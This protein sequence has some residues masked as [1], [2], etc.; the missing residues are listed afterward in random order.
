MNNIRKLLVLLAWVVVLGCL[1]GLGAAAGYLDNEALGTRLAQLAEKSPGL[2]TVR[3]L[4]KSQE[5]HEV[6]LVELGQ[7][8][9][10]DRNNAPAMLVV[11]GIEGND[12][13]GTTAVIEWIERL[14]GQPKA[15]LLLKE[16]EVEEGGLP[17]DTVDEKRKDQPQQ[18]PAEPM[19]LRK[20]P[21]EKP[22]PIDGLPSNAT[23]YVIPR[24]N[25]DAAARFFAK[26]PIESAT[27]NKPFDD[28]HDG[29]V[30]ED[31]PEDLN[32]DGQ[33]TM[34]RIRDPEGTY[35]L[36]PNEPRLLIEADKMKGEAGAWKL[37]AEGRDNDAD[38]KWNED[39]RGGV[40]FNR[41]FPFNYEWFA[42]DAGVHQVSEPETRALAD[43][44]VAHPNISV[45]FTFG[46]GDNLLAPP[47]GGKREGRKPLTKIDEDD[48]PYYKE[49][50]EIYRKALG[51]EKGL[52]N[53]TEPG[54]F[55]D[56]IYFHRGRLSLAARPWSPELHVALAEANKDAEKS[57]ESDKSDKP[58]RSDE[59]EKD[60]GDEKKKAEKKDD[61]D[62]RGKD[63]RK[64]LKWV[65]ENAPDLFVPWTKYEH[66][67]FPGQ[68]VEIGGFTA[69]A[70]TNPP[71][72]VLEDLVARQA[73]FLTTLAL[74]LP[75]I[76][77]RK[78]ESKPLGKSVYEIKIQVENT[79]YLPTS[80]KHG[81]TTR[82]VFPTRIELDLEDSQVLSGTRI[83][84]L[85]K[86][87]GSGGWHETRWIVHAP[88]KKEI[89]VKV[90]SMLGG[91]IEATLELDGDKR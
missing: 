91:T 65:D 23:I 42:A 28:D 10:A 14:L 56:W 40:N 70:K 26:P 31:G 66:P 76:G 74:R 87:E 84:R 21:G 25:P 64:F 35:I 20:A 78:M 51:L 37:M 47:E 69:F 73:D 45:V 77:I 29:L 46:A 12:L 36:D 3:S 38:E 39:G 58:D 85:P 60:S 72:K 24:M 16:P 7:G 90:R 11:A 61:G 68:Q 2:V 83:T 63:K 62:E 44:A 8:K 17:I 48:L 19:K 81:E 88:D 34:M 27:N 15:R 9:E 6:W 33:V 22:E 86:L 75:R 41:N 5:D 54:T 50:G 53:N 1:P 30:D 71:E 43:F 67:D 52:K 49:F 55:S 13:A 82:E 4:V 80:L 57:K 79:G 18:M 89:K 32:G 59:S